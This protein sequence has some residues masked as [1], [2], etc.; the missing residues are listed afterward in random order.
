MKL[1]FDKAKFS[2]KFDYCTGKATDLVDPALHG[3]AQEYRRR[4]SGAMK[5]LS[6]QDIYKI[7]KTKG[8]YATRKYDGEFALLAFDGKKMISVNPGGTVRVGLPAFDE[9]EKLLAKAKIKSCLLGGELYLTG[10]TTKI[11]RVSG[12]VK[13]LRSPSSKT[14]LEKIGVAVFDVIELD[15]NPVDKT[16]KVFEI[17][18]SLFGKGKLVHPVDN[19]VANT[20]DAVMAIFTDWVIGE[21]SEG[22][23]LRHDQAG[24][25]KIKTRHNLDA[26]VIGFSE[27]S[28]DRKGL[29]HDLLVAVI[30]HDG[31]FHEL[32]RVGGGF[33]DEDRRII[34]DELRRRI[35]PSDYVAVNNDYVAYEMIA[36]GPVIEMSCLDLIAESSR[37]G[38]VKRMVLDWD[39]K[40]YT[41]LSRMPLVSVISPQFVRMRDDKEANVEDVNIRQVAD[42]VEVTDIEKPAHEDEAPASTLLER[43][44]YTKTMR[45]NQ[46]VRKLLLWKTNK[47]DKPDFP[48]Y[49]IYLTDFSPNRKN[50][51]ERDIRI[52][53]TE[54]GARKLFSE[55]AEKNFISGWEKV[56]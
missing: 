3:R 16:A 50:P 54:K 49:V 17:L 29:L 35:V 53:K 13:I 22:I 15:G 27:G 45:G 44:V 30:R 47:D 14:E 2:C 21:G 43:T 46:M 9:A 34:A 36:P 28:E 24:L 20:V 52:A 7:P 1:D 18:K 41:A 40:R 10:D 31:T 19:L 33:T 11:N 56:V 55:M 4:L 23:V 37:G 38:P 48:G 6:G 26:A 5:A 12:V 39:G 32:C 25:Y 42:L 8:F 51:L